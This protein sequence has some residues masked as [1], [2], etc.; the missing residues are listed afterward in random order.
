MMKNVNFTGFILIGSIIISIILS[1]FFS[2]KSGCLFY[3]LFNI[4]MYIH[5]TITG[6]SNAF[7]CRLDST[8]DLFW[9]MFFMII[10][11]ISLTIYFSI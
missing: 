8:P 10:G 2:I 7:I 11:I 1:L 5:I 4:G 6:L 9:K 3:A